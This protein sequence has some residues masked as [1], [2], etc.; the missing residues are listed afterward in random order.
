MNGRTKEG[1]NSWLSNSDALFTF[2]LIAARIMENKLTK[3]CL[4]SIVTWIF[5]SV[6]KQMHSIIEQRPRKF[7]GFLVGIFPYVIRYRIL[8]KTDSFVYTLK[9]AVNTTF[10][11][12]LFPVV[13]FCF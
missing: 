13:K 8:V 5:F 10:Y 2:V 1:E 7:F 6:V 12:K 3:K 11:L 4:Q 9:V